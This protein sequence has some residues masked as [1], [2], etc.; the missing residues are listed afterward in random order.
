MSGSA[1]RV[2]PGAA[3]LSGLGDGSVNAIAVHSALRS[4]P[5]PVSRVIGPLWE[6]VVGGSS[7]LAPTNCD[8]CEHFSPMA[9]APPVSDPLAGVS[10]AFRRGCSSTLSVGR[11]TMPRHGQDAASPVRDL[12][13]IL[14]KPQG[15]A[16][17]KRTFQADG[18]SGRSAPLLSSPYEPSALLLVG[19]TR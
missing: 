8:P 2:T 5:S 10:V 6:Q 17:I 15:Q 1:S 7:P 11:W 12:H 14:V 9:E 18:P 4:P 3:T 19:T 16:S 13:R